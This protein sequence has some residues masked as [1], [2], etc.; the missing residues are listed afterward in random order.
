MVD[1]TRAFAARWGRVLT[2][3]TVSIA[4]V[5]TVLLAA[6]PSDAIVPPPTS[7]PPVRTTAP[8]S[9]STAPT[10]PTTTQ[11]ATTAASP[12][13]QPPPPPPP[14]PP[15]PAPA[16]PE[17]ELQPVPEPP[18]QRDAIDDYYTATKDVVLVV[19]YEAGLGLNDVLECGGPGYTI[20]NLTDPP[21]GTVVKT[22]NDFGA[23]EYTPDLGFTG[24][25]SFSYTLYQGQDV[26]DQAT[27][28]ITVTESCTVIGFTDLY[29]T[30]FETPVSEP[31]P[32]FLANDTVEC[33]PFAANIASP[34]AD[35]T[36]TAGVDGAFVYT[37]DPGFWGSDEFTYEILD[38][39]QVVMGAAVVTIVVDKPPCVAID[40]A[41]STTVDTTLTVGAPGVLGNDFV[42]PDLSSLQ[43][44]QPPVNGS[45]TLQ[46]DGS[47]E[48]VPDPGFVGQD[49][50]TYDHV[51]FDIV[52]AQDVV[53]ATASVVIDV[54]ETP[55]TTTTAAAT[56][57]IASGE[58]T[59]TVPSGETS[60][61]VDTTGTS[62][63]DTS[64]TTAPGPGP[65]TPPS[66]V[67]EGGF[68]VATF[69]ASL[70]R[71]AEGELV[72]DLTTPDDQQAA[73][74]AAILQH[75]RPD[76]V[77][78]NEFDYV[79]GGA[80]VD[81][82]RTNYLL[83]SQNGAQPIDYPYL[84]IAP[85]NTG[86]PSGLDLDNDG[87]VGGANDAFGFG[88]FPG[89]YGMVVLSRFPIVEDQVRT[90]QNLLWSS[91]PGA[92]LPD[93]PA[94][95]EPADWYSPDELAVLRLSSKSHW[96]VPID[97]AG[98]IVHILAS[99]PTPPVF[100]GPEDRNG[101]RNADEI[102]FWADYVAGSDTGWIIDDAGV[103]GGLPVDAEFVIVGD[104]NSDPLDGD[105]LAG[106]T[107]QVLALDRVQDPAPTSEGAVEAAV[108]QGLQNG[109]QAGD[110]ALDTADFPDDTPGNLRV[111]Y[112]LPSDGFTLVDAGVFWPATDDELSRLVTIEP[113]ASSDHR[114]VWVDLG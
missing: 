9:T 62:E 93:D 70:N 41:Y 6:A 10:R 80:A 48:Y 67:P 90:F 47:F 17:D 61:P 92:R 19:P 38:A 83:L 27:A 39:N 45:V 84:F 44:S 1:V 63:P 74:V 57:T 108:A 12:T 97:V 85:S 107:D 81:L 100:D 79:E 66:S 64:P 51:K 89:Q 33:Q 105:S 103:S 65:E 29:Y 11:P 23:F 76:V 104:L 82:F 69:N 113:L 75:T 52:T 5:G 60:T 40:D 32:G 18:C 34:P 54:T 98:Q 14:P 99:H 56:T 114:L 42:C 4:V 30:S 13:T 16:P 68:R 109:I 24:S 71:A 22:P 110:P 31:A 58:T 26:A 21:N 59:T 94:T 112:V 50:F 53:L 35:G 88:D 55:V 101:M 86:I 36:L 106:A 20:D 8:P 43:V 73:N 7:A 96:D 3:C 28:Y 111:D 2:A 37:P 25:D 91:M 49:L 95:P 87:T 46:V 15:Q 77:L 72:D 78:L 102:G